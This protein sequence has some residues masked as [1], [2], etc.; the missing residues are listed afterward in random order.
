MV[1]PAHKMVVVQ[2]S[3]GVPYD[4]DVTAHTRIRSGDRS[5]DWSGLSGNVNKS[6]S[7]KFVPER[8]GDVATSIRIGG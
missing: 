7:V 3:D 5:I 8:K 4:L 2:S 6:V 1:D